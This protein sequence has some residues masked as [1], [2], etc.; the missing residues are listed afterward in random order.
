ML[1]APTHRNE[2]TE[3]EHIESLIA[4]CQLSKAVTT[5]FHWEA[6]L[7][8]LICQWK[9]TRIVAQLPHREPFG[10]VPEEVRLWARHDGPVIVASQLDGFVEQITDGVD[11]YLVQ[12]RNHPEAADKFTSILKLS[13]V[14]TKQIKGAGHRRCLGIRYDDRT[15][16]DDVPNEATVRRIREILDG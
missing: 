1:L 5:I 12:P 13:E 16:F 8:G 9:H 2:N 15:F 4:R 14:Q 6:N 11:G 10:L 3:V 7:P